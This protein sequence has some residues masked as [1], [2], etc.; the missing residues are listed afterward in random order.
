LSRATL[1][2]CDGLTQN[3][4]ICSNWRTTAVPKNVTD[5]PI[6]GITAS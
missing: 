1:I 6:R 5:A 4:P 3:T 2:A